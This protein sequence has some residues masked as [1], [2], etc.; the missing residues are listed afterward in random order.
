MVSIASSR[1]HEQL[2]NESNVNMKGVLR[3][4]NIIADSR[5]ILPV[6][7]ISNE[8]VAVTVKDVVR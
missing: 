8:R 5:L 3:N 2:L 4:M 6:L 1:Q 7:P